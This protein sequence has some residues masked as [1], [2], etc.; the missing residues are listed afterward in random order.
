[1][2]EDFDKARNSSHM[3]ELGSRQK[4]IKEKFTGLRK[5]IEC[6]WS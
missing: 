5:M 4:E 6:L 1:M 2:T 3:A